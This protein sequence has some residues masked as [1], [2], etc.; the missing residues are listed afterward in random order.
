MHVDRVVFD[1]FAVTQPLIDTLEILRVH[2][3]HT[4]TTEAQELTPSI[5][6][7]DLVV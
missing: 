7:D 6:L 2:I 5:A 4:E 3:Y 1:D